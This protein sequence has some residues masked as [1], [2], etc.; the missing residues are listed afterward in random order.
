MKRG[1]EKWRADLLRA[2]ALAYY[3]TARLGL[4]LQ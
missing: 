1:M 2:P 3:A 4:V